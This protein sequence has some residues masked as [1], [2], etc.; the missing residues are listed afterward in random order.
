MACDLNKGR[1]LF[2]SEAAFVSSECD[3]I[4]QIM[5]NPAPSLLVLSLCSG[6]GMKL[7]FC[8]TFD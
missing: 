8:V 3:K 2:L 7:I 1:G 6:D 4:K 5:P